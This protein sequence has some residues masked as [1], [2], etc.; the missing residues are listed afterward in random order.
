MSDRIELLPCPFCGGE[1]RMM[2]TSGYD[3]GPAFRVECSN[4]GACPVE[5]KTVEYNGEAYAASRWNERYEPEP[6]N[7][8]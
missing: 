3:A 1:A 2:T 5:P 8:D 6:D 7:A 4:W